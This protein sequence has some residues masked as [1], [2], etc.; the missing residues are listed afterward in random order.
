M[1]TVAFAEDL[2][3]WAVRLTPDAEDLALADRALT[4]TAAVLLAARPHRVAGLLEPFDEAGAWAV[5]AHV[6]DFDDLHMTSTTHISA[7]CVPAAL[8]TGAGARGYLAGAGVMARL[9][10][11]LGWPHYTAGWHATCTAGALGAAAV[12]GVALGLD[13]ERT[14]TALA[15]AVPAAGGVQQ[16]F[17]TDAKPLQV[18]MAV[19][20]GVRAAR[21]AAAG[22]SA[23]PRAVDQW[24]GLLGRTELDHGWDTQP[25]VP[26][27]LAI[28]LFPCCYAIQRPIH[29]VRSLGPIDPATVRGIRVRALAAT[30]QPLIHHRPT[31]GPEGKFSLEY[32]IAAAILDGWPGLESFTDRAVAR[33]EAQELLRL[34]ETDLEPGGSGLLD[35]RVRLEV[36]TTDGTLVA[37]LEQTPASP[38]LPPTADQLAAKL[39]DCLGGAD[40]PD[41]S[42]PAGADVLREALA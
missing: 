36:E 42:W 6:L 13:A 7:V 8:A 11:V 9:G 1:Q 35:G 17:G 3:A 14:A 20:A 30:V 41:L 39:A 27:G 33:P 2:A 25:A 10:T 38:S 28:K 22:A 29:A 24:A 23:D 16:A 26:G 5:L 34:V 15:L 19:D 31:T 12:A 18:G 32:G 37:E 21:L 4:D 40:A